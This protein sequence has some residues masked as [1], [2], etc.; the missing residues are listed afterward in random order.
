MRLIIIIFLLTVAI[1]SSISTKCHEE[2]GKTHLQWTDGSSTLELEKINDKWH[3]TSTKKK[4]SKNKNHHK[5]IS[6]TEEST[7]E[8]TTTEKTT[9]TPKYTQQTAKT[10][11]SPPRKESFLYRILK[12][13]PIPRGILNYFSG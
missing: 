12:Y 1:S 4:H 6:T 13:L 2:K 3:S 11:A 10:T 8:K 5:P 7:T 9:T